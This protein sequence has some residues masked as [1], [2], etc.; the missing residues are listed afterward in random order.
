MV[1]QRMK[2]IGENRDKLNNKDLQ[3]DSG[4]ITFEYFFNIPQ[5]Q[6]INY[7]VTTPFAL[8]RNGKAE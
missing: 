6:D 1:L 3:T 7:Q 2:S 8:A 5:K 4:G